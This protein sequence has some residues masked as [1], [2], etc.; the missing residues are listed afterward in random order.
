MTVWKPGA[1]HGLVER[2]E[3]INDLFH[4]IAE[5]AIERDKEQLQKVIKLKEIQNDMAEKS[6]NN[7]N[8]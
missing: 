3:R 7:T 5:L 1:M 6:G 2:L 8:L 4:Q